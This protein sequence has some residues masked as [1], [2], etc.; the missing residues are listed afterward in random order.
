MSYRERARTVPVSFRERP[1]RKAR[2]DLIRG[3]TRDTPQ[4]FMRIKKKRGPHA[5]NA[6]IAKR[7]KV[8]FRI[9]AQVGHFRA[10]A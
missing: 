7:R 2:E 5:E 6:K 1:R 4:R 10:A 9:K 8:Y 3:R